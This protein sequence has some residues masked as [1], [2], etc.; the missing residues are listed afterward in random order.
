M[1]KRVNVAVV[2]GLV[3]VAVGLGVKFGRYRIFA[4]RFEVVEAGRIHRG[5]EQEAGP[6]RRIVEQYGL[7]TVVTLLDN[8]PEDRHQIIEAELVQAH[9]LKC[10]RFPMPGDGRGSFDAL[11]AAAAALADADNY[12]LFVHCAA[13]VHRTGATIAAYRMKY[14]G[15]DLERALAELD[16]HWTSPRGNAQLYEHLKTYY[17]ERVAGAR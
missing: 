12:P 6:Y 9:G 16:E 5:G 4:K 2:V 15:W 3:A 17:A 7:R 14:C 8:R 13:G 11:D 10:L 1:R